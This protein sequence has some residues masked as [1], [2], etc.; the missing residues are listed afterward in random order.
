[1]SEAKES[2]AL[3]SHTIARGVDDQA[4]LFQALNNSW[5]PKVQTNMGSLGHRFPQCMGASSIYEDHLAWLF[6]DGALLV[7]PHKHWFA[8]I[9]PQSKF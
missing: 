8:D 5:D 4:N 1:M 7:V 6:V 2:H 9:G 3:L